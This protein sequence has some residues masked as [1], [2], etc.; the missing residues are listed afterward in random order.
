MVVE[1]P[2]QICTVGV[3]FLDLR[4]KIRN[5]LPKFKWGDFYLRNI[6]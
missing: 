2:S 6:S 5:Y 4:D 1:V 3:I